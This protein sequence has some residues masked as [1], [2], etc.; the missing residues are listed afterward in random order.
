MAMVSR[1]VPDAQKTAAGHLATISARS[2][3][4]F[5][6]FLEQRISQ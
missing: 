2:W 3:R 4:R 6:T 1:S 5:S